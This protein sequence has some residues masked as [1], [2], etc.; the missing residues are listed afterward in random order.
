[1]LNPVPAKPAAVNESSVPAPSPA[2]KNLRRWLNGEAP[3]GV[4][5]IEC[6][7]LLPLRLEEALGQ[8]SLRVI[9]EA[10]SPE[11]STTVPWETARRDFKNG[12]AVDEDD[13]R[14]L[15]ALEKT[16]GAVA[17]LNAVP[18]ERWAAF[19]RSLAG[20]PRIWLG[21]KERIEVHAAAD[22]PKIFLHRRPDGALELNPETEAP[23]GRSLPLAG[24]RFDGHALFEIPASLEN[25]PRIVS[26]ADLPDFLLREC[27]VLKR[28]ANSFSRPASRNFPWKRSGPP[29]KRGSK[30]RFPGLPLISLRIITA[31]LRSREQGG[32]GAKLFRRSGP[33]QPVL[34]ARRRD[35]KS[36]AGGNRGGRLSS[37]AQRRRHLQPDSGKSGRPFSGQY[38]A[39]AGGGRGRSASA[40]GWKRRCAKS[41]S[42]SPN[43][44]C[45]RG[46]GEDW[47]SLDLKLSVRGQTGRRSIRPKSSAG[48]RPARATRARRTSACCSCRPRRGARCR[49]CWPI[50]RWSRSRE[51]CASRGTFA[52]FLAGALTAQGFRAGRK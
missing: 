33:D 10:R 30:A 14:L 39:R 50:A 20:H 16:T 2:Q 45:A 26:R 36:G 47:L 46:S 32:R 49:R 3:A 51:G 52:P 38:S 9:L 24:W 8:N 19:L 18:R 37:R 31:A 13:A 25:F 44:R 22:R 4:P 27:R 42:P 43:F 34:A 6:A 35:G 12:F 7:A 5:A 40:R 21:K 48:C 17:G 15:D 11:G 41:T 1:M 29:S 28:A 23:P